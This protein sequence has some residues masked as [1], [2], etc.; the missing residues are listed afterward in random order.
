MF[1]THPVIPL[2]KWLPE[3]SLIYT[4]LGTDEHLEYSSLTGP[5]AALS[6]G[7]RAVTSPSQE[8]TEP[9]GHPRV[10]HTSVPCVHAHT[11]A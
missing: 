10:R 11:L 6:A 8:K 1:Y 9:L 3:G 2:W 5:L 7:R 4:S